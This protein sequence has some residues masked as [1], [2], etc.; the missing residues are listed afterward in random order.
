MN[1]LD[2]PRPVARD[3]EAANARLA[4]FDIKRR[5]TSTFGDGAFVGDFLGD[6]AASGC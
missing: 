3:P 6:G 5:A 2:F 4:G 1:S